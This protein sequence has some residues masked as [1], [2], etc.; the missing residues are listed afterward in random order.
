MSDWT[1][2]YTAEIDYTHGYYGE[3]NPQRLQFAFAYNGLAFPKIGTACELGF[4]QGMSVNLH[5]AASV[6]KWW[7][8]DFNPS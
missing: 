4:G 8:T 1:A 2:G 6:V 3:L 7:G 5:A